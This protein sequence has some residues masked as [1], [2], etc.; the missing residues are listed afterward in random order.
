MIKNTYIFL[1]TYFFRNIPGSIGIKLRYLFYKPLFNSCGKNINIGIGVIINNFSMIK[2]GNHIRIDDYTTLNVGNLN[3]KRYVKTKKDLTLRESQIKLIIEDY[4]HI[5]QYCLISSFNYLEINKHC[6]F[7]SG[8]KIYNVSHHFRNHENKSEIIYSN[9][10]D[11]KNMTKKSLYVS[12]I[13]FEENVF[14]SLNS[15]ILDGRIGKNTF[16]YPNSIVFSNIKE[17]SLYKINK[18]VGNRFK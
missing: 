9:N 10:L 1:V 14:V 5:N 12:E 13:I 2:L 18:I 3:S 17:N 7:S 6:T 16:I 8:V 11:K 4:V 15:I